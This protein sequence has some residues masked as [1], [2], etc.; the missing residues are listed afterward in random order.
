MSDL[1]QEYIAIGKIGGPWG[2]RGEAKLQLYNAESEVL[3]K[4][5]FVYLKAGF[6]FRKL[7]LL[8][9]KSQGKS[10]VIALEGYAS[11][12][13]VRE[14][15]GQELF[16]PLKELAP[17]KPGEFYVHEMIGMRVEDE[18]GNEIG[19]VDSLANYGS[20]DLLTILS[21]GPGSP[22]EILIPWIEDV[23]AGVDE[24]GRRIIVRRL[25]GL[26]D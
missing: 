16:V 19:I 15:L 2:L 20:A 13:A 26:L 1:K 24:A 17:K 11:P 4:T 7:G 23:I 12:E 22:R 3:K 9:W 6:S 14:L 5:R 8:K 25:E 21:Q 18:E 10:S